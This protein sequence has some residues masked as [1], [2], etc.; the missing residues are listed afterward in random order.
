MDRFESAL[1]GFHRGVGLLKSLDSDF[2][3]EREAAR[4]AAACAINLGEL[5][6]ESSWPCTERG[7]NDF[8]A[9]LDAK[10]ATPARIRMTEDGLDLRVELLG[11]NAAAEAS[12]QALAVFLLTI[13]GG[14]RMARAYAM[15]ADGQKSF[16][17]QVWLPA[18]PASEEIDHALAA[19]SIAHRICARETSVLLDEAAARCYLVARDLSTTN[20]PQHQ[21][22]N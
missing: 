9:E 8:S 22:E 7:P 15:E 10:S 2:R 6:R 19:L 20:E 17:F 21:E 1:G 4:D 13:S 5:L 14:L 12:R 16:G 18:T 11:S 3:G